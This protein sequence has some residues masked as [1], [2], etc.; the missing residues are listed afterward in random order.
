[1][2]TPSHIPCSPFASVDGRVSVI[3]VVGLIRIA[4]NCQNPSEGLA[5]AQEL[6][7]PGADLFLSGRVVVALIHYAVTD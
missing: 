2:G 7:A 6:L 5:A 3:V 1:M 4:P